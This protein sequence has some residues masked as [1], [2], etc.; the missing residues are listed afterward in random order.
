[1][2]KVFFYLCTATLS[3]CLLASDASAQRRGG[4]G[5]DDGGGGRPAPQFNPGN[6]NP[7]PQSQPDP[8]VRVPDVRIP[9]VRVPEVRVPGVGGD[10]RGRVEGGVRVGDGTV[11]GRADGSAGGNIR[12]GDGRVRGDG[13]LDGRVDGSVRR[14]GVN[15]PGTV[16]RGVNQ[17]IYRN[18]INI[19]QRSFNIAPNN[20][21]GPSQNYAWHRGYWNNSYGWNP[22]IGNGR[23]YYGN[24]GGYGI[25]LGNIY[26]GTGGNR[27][28]GGYGYGRYPIGWGYGGW[29]LG[30]TYY[31]SGYG[32]YFNPY[33]V[34]GGNNFAYNYAQPIYVST[35]TSATSDVATSNFDSAR[36]AFKARDYDMAFAWV[37]R[38]IK[39]N[40]SDE[41]LHEFRSLTQ[42]AQK[43][44]SGAAATIHS[45]L[46]V[47]PG[48]DWST[49]ASLYSDVSEY[50]AQLR[51]LESFTKSNPDDAGSQLLLGYHYMTTGYPE[52][53]AREFA[54]VVKLQP[55]DRVAKDLFNLVN[56][57]DEGDVTA[58][59][60]PREG[61]PAAVKPA[62][63]VR[64]ISVNTLAGQ[65]KSTR[66][67]GS[68][69]GLDLRDDKTFTWKFNQGDRKE[70]FSGTYTTEGSLL[71]LQK[72]DGGAMVGHVIQ[73][74]DGKFTFKLLGAPAE[75]PGLSFTH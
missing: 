73:E 54:Q 57:T 28:Y 7:R 9:N 34:G 4:R 30:N 39:E 1:M 62:E 56:K 50:T 45:V 19:G 41:V 15:F 40:P 38:A 16:D 10:G 46:A 49:M 29:G 69:F 63:D 47:G 71:L 43:D 17:A 18:N 32:S 8:A 22:Q 3:M 68:K 14:A 66:E 64:P 53:A 27:G 48:W 5:R 70:D 35:E 13:N 21:R 12:V 61:E 36:E 59:P 37:N 24:Y 23:G 67:D 58:A 72:Q 11:R 65:W 42:F 6:N 75:D 31:R 33:W 26:L 2:K 20:Y 52:Q 60:A 74:G 55:K 44:Y 25:R 51:T